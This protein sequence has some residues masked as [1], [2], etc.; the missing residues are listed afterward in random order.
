VNKTKPTKKELVEKFTE[1]NEG[2]RREVGDPRA[3]LRA[4]PLYKQSGYTESDF[5]EYWNSHQDLIKECSPELSTVKEEEL[6]SDYIKINEAYRKEKDNPRAFIPVKALFK[7]SSYKEQ[8]YRQFWNNSEEIRGAAY[9]E[10]TQRMTREDINIVKNSSHK[11]DK[12]LRFF[13]TT[14]LPDS[15]LHTGFFN[16]IQ[17]YC[18]IKKAEL[19]ILPGRGVHHTHVHYHPE[20]EAKADFFAT[21]Y[22]IGSN[23]KVIEAKIPPMSPDPIQQSKRLAKHHSLILAHPKQNM[24]SLPVL[25]RSKPKVILSTGV[26]TTREYPR[27]TS[28]YKGELESTLGGVIVEYERET[29]KFFWRFVQADETDGSFIDI[30]TQ[31]LANGKTKKVNAEYLYAGDVHAS[32]IAEH[33]RK[34]TIDQANTLGV[35]TVG[36]GDWFDSY[37]IS[38]HHE[39]DIITQVLKYQDKESVSTLKAELETFAKELRLWKKELNKGIEIDIIKSN[40]DEHLNRYLKERRFFDDKHNYRLSLELTCFM[41]DRLDPIQHYMEI[42]HP[43]LKKGI[44]WISRGHNK[45]I[46]TK[47]ILVSEHGDLGP[48]GSKSTNTNAE[49]SLQDCVLGHSHSPSVLRGVYRVGVLAPDLE[50]SVDRGP[51]SWQIMNCVIYPNGSRQMLWIDSKG[52]WHF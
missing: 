48:N 1:L 22:S 51:S 45:K 14:V 10:E 36:A 3:F 37:S 16:S 7:K 15:E 30:G 26:I 44:N 17:S 27:T 13:I 43:D 42:Y 50:Y 40:H 38:H 4:K 31:Y 20:V 6:I 46:T 2:Y 28:G 33:A 9:P 29:E 39:K 41:L 11:K 35:K 5:R 23:L 47:K 49:W 32:F 12:I 24:V 21:E 19:V 34:A 25:D 18:K 52:K 8:D